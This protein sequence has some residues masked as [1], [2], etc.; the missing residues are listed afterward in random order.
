MRFGRSLPY[1][2]TTTVVFQALELA[3]HPIYCHKLYITLDSIYLV[4][5][6]AA[7]LISKYYD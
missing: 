1:H 5:D 6:N 7:K 4:G 3:A 2:S